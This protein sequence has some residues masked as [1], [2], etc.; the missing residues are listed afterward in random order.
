MSR[1]TLRLVAT[2][3]FAFSLLILYQRWEAFTTPENQSVSAP[4]VETP[5]VELPA[6]SIPSAETPAPELPAIVQADEEPAAPGII[7][8]S[9]KNDSLAVG[10]DS[11]G[12]LAHAELLRHP[13]ALG[14]EPLA[15][16]NIDSQ[17]KFIA[18]SGLIGDS[19]PNHLDS[20]WQVAL[21]NASQ[22]PNAV[23]SSF[24]SD[25]ISVERIF[26]LADTGYLA[27]YTYKITNNSPAPISGHVYF[28]FLRDSQPPPSYSSLVP[29]YYGAAIYT[30]EANYSKYA[31]DDFEDYPNN[32]TNGWIG[33][34]Q[35]YFLSA[36]LDA[37]GFREYYM[38]NLSNG[39]VSVGLLRPFNP[40][41]PGEVT[42]VT[43]PLFIGALEQ[44]LLNEIEPQGGQG[45]NLAVDYGILTI[46]CAP[47]FSLLSAIHSLVG[48]WGFAIILL[49]VLLKLLFFP[50][51]A[52][53]YRSMAKMKALSP[54]I[55][56]LRERAGDD[57]QAMQKE[58]MDLYRKEKVNPFGGCLPILIQIPVF[59]ALY[60]V[61]LESVELRQAPLGLW[62]QDL[63]IPD[64]YYVLP[65]LLC[66][67][68]LGQFKLNPTP[69]DPTQAMVMKIMPIGF[70]IFAIFFPAGLVI[71]WVVNT[72]LSIAQQWQISHRI[73]RTAQK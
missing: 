39:D 63:S 12:T 19:L 59:I 26:K 73:G 68:M 49:T 46:L 8:V 54:Q 33:I 21:S 3:A 67:V 23:I 29:S 16:L 37:E 4:V 18:Q 50:L 43:Q 57:R 6:P 65:V 71:Y 52:K 40:I 7:T 28:Q 66:L 53:S 58:I 13:I 56:A 55:Q 61:L 32:G 11:T 69:P 64:P 31:F 14:G 25:Q 35:R 70:A 17:R 1:D 9:V 72:L 27:E 30:E 45:I 10:F 36:W 44:D 24:S 51:S 15:L 34:V 5:A 47:L 38:R 42:V 2:A 62:L 20:G 41:A 22:T 60:W 48:N